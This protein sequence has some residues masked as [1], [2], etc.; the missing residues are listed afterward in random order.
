M[1]SG[2][3]TVRETGLFPRMKKVRSVGRKRPERIGIHG[4]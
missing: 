1:L 2:I 3:K 4:R